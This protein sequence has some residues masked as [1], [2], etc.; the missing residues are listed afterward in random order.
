MKKFLLLLGGILFL[1]LNS[2]SAQKLFLGPELGVNLSPTIETGNA[3][4]YQLGVNG[5]LRLSYAFNDKFS[6][7]SGVYFTQKHQ[8]FDS[9]SVGSVL[10]VIN[11]ALGGFGGGGFDAEELLSGIGGAGFNLDVNRQYEG[12]IKANF[13]EIPLMVEVKTGKVGFS[14]GGYA[15]YMVSAESNTTITETTPLLQVIDIEEL[16]GE[17]GGGVG[18]LFN[19]FLPA[20]NG[21]TTE[22]DDSK[23][24]YNAF[25]YGIKGGISYT[26]SDNLIFN[27]SYQHGLRDYRFNRPVDLE[28]TPDINEQ[29]FEPFKNINFTMAY[30]FGLKKKADSV[31]TP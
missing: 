7:R 14:L 3:Q 6:L 27:L 16:L 8:S 18:G 29:T 21:V 17:V 25:D 28:E 9:T 31:F 24:N 1:N 19:L 15:A 13:I 12:T 26:S 20:A 22:I 23:G 4:N 11:G 2:I 10:D 5:G 30:Q